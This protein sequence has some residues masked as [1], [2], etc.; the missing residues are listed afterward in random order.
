MKDKEESRRAV[1]KLEARLA[2]YRK[3]RAICPFAERMLFDELIRQTEQEIRA[4]SGA[5]SKTGAQDTSSD[6]QT[7]RGNDAGTAHN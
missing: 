7:K 5:A 3:N 4:F 6:V 2:N 1:A